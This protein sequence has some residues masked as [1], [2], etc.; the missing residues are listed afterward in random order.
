MSTTDLSNDSHPLSQKCSAAV[1]QSGTTPI[2]VVL[3]SLNEGHNIAEVAEN[4]RGW[5]SEVILVDS[6]S[7]DDTVNEALKVG[8]KVVQRRFRDFGDQ[9]NFAVCGILASQP[10]TM[11]LDPDERISPSLKDSLDGAI[12]R[13]DADALEV[14]RSLWFMKRRLPVRQK[15]IRVWRTGNCRFTEVKVNEHPIVSGRVKFVSGD[16]EHHD[17]PDLEHWFEKQNKYT[18]AEAII[19]YRGLAL[20]DRPRLFGNSLQRRMWLKAR[21]CRLPGRYLLLFLYH[22]LVQGAFRAGIIGWVWSRLR[23]DVMRMIEYK[24]LEMQVTG[25]TPSGRVYGMG[26]PDLRVP[27]Y[28]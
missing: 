27:Q 11:K 3:I 13:G 14:S 7:K 9:W 17:S 24:T 12:R 4:L 22:F 2:T 23:V 21:F 1:W 5:A 8:F 25:Q 20:A 15:L 19:R 10:W 28:D 18:T 26:E 16:L 6:Y